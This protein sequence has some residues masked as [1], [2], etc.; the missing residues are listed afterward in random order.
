MER[1]DTYLKEIKSR[2][3]LD[4]YT[5]VR[6]IR[7]LQSHFEEEVADLQQ[8]GVPP[9]DSAEEAIRSSGN[10]HS[11]A[12]MFYEAHSRAS[13]SE[14]LLA[15]QPHLV[16]S[17]LFLTHLWTN[18]A[19][20]AVAFGG[21]LLITFY[22]WGRGRPNWVYPWIGYSFS[23]FVAAIFFSRT[24]VYNSAVDLIVGSR[25]YSSH[26]WLL[27][28]LG[29]YAVF[30]WLVVFSVV[31]VVRRDWLLVSFMLLP[32]PVFGVWISDM[33]RIGAAFYTSE[34][35]AYRWDGGM[36]ASL[37]LLGVVAVLF[38]RLRRR[39][40]RILLLAASCV[41]STLL[42]GKSILESSRFLTIPML[43]GLAM[44][45]FLVP[46]LLEWVLGHGEPIGSKSG[47]L[48]SRK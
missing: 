33:A 13:W 35:A 30:V 40:L 42:V 6:I 37:L 44:F 29:L 27:L 22:G 9:A 46:A 18:P 32:L 45:T 48:P 2:L 4:P 8:N 41:A 24:F 34:P 43:V 5:E 7:E 12:L 19:A 1:I 20:V 25:L 26:V 23:P 3:H 47:T 14:A 11:L 16:A 31:R 10:A 39:L 17:A 36:A 28:F 38:L 21:V 15:L